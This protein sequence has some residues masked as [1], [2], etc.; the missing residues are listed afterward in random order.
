VA[1]V[2]PRPPGDKTWINDDAAPTGMIG[3]VPCA[4]AATKI[5]ISA[6][7]DATKALGLEIL[8]LVMPM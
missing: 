3:A 4:R 7:Q 5:K 1:E 6:G 8:A 2:A